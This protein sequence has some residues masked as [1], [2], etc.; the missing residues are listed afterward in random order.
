MARPRQPAKHYPRVARLNEVVLE[1]LAGELERLS[2]PRLGF[3][4]LTG[5]EV[6]RDL[7]TAE[8]FYSVMGSPEEH[9]ETAA[10]LASAEPHL[11]SVL[12]RAV[13]MK[14]VPALVFREDPSLE[15]GLRIDQLIRDLHTADDRADSADEH[16]TDGADA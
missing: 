13:R 8:V 11:K 10:G 7:R 9:A 5:V 16:P 12:S 15:T 14:Y 3:V 1:C 2:D 6:N 4:T